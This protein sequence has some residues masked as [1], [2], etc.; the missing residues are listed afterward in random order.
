MFAP[1]SSAV[2]PTCTN[3]ST[4]SSRSSSAKIVGRELRPPSTA[5]SEMISSMEV[6]TMTADR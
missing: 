4:P 5:V 6:S 3:V 1:T 2:L